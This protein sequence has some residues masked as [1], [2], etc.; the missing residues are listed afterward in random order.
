MSTQR[1]KP[2]EELTIPSPRRQY[3]LDAEHL[4]KHPDEYSHKDL[5]ASRP[6]ESYCRA[7]GNRVT[8]TTERIE[9][10]HQAGDQ[11]R[12]PHRPASVD[13]NVPGRDR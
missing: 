11:H 7:C 1:Q 4:A 9:L 13:P 3:I 10:G 8:V 12:C 2:L 6:G 5:G